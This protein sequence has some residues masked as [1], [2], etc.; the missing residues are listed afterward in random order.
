MDGATD[1][2]AENDSPAAVFRPS[3]S[4]DLLFSF[5]PSRALTLLSLP[6]T[7]ALA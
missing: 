2:P 3:L 5:G 6:R 4:T 7:L 1:F